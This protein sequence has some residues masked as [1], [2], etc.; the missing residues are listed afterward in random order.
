MIHLR[1]QNE[2]RETVGAIRQW[3]LRVTWDGPSYPESAVS[4]NVPR[5]VQSVSNFWSRG[6]AIMLF[7]T[8]KRV[9]VRGQY[10]II[11]Q[12]LRYLFHL[13]SEYHRQSC[14]FQRFWHQIYS[15]LSTIAIMYYQMGRTLCIYWYRKTGILFRRYKLYSLR[16]YRRFSNQPKWN[17]F[18]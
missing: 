11:L 3:R 7:Y 1:I 14:R 6:T 9:C 18:S 2:C 13:P 4:S 12:F 16:G 17:M 10:F 5:N 8:T 15:S